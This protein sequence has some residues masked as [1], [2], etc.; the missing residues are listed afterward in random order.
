MSEQL[1]LKDLEYLL[2]HVFLPPKLP[3]EDDSD[4]ERDIV[5]CQQMY[6]ATREFERF[7]PQHQRQK[8]SVV[9]RMLEMLLQTTQFL[10]NDLLV[11]NI[12]QLGDG[13]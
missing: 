2:N 1:S 7:L 10:N 6:R 3:Q 11:N 4:K 5:L 12:L 13:G 9:T 8:W